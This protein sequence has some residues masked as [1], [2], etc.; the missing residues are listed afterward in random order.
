MQYAV[1]CIDT[2]GGCNGGDGYPAF[3]YYINNGTVDRIDYP[4]TS[5]ANG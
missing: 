2:L 4:Y 1:S 3:E 5:G